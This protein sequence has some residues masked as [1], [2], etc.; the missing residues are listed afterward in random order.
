MDTKLTNRLPAQ[1]P[2]CFR[3]NLRLVLVTEDAVRH[4]T[5]DNKALCSCRC[6]TG[7]LPDAA[8]VEVGNLH[9][10]G[11]AIHAGG[12]SRVKLLLGNCTQRP[13]KLHNGLTVQLVTA[14]PHSMLDQHADMKGSPTT[15]QKT[16]R[17]H[18]HTRSV[19][20]TT[21]RSIPKH[22]AAAASSTGFAVVKALLGT[23]QKQIV[24][25]FT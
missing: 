15:S 18:A 2:G 21:M 6:D 20:Y 14:P 5:E 8:H 1:V 12:M 16:H 7:S 13:H 17:G 23:E 10:L 22:A 9:N 3:T 25:A 4:V 24:A 19:W 11:E